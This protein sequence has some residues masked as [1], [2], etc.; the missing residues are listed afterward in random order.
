MNEKEKAYFKSV[1]H[2]LSQHAKN[3]KDRIDFDTKVLKSKVD[4][5][6]DDIISKS[7][8]LKY[9]NQ[10]IRFLRKYL[11]ELPP[12]LSTIY[13]EK[14]A[15]KTDY[16]YSIREDV[17][18][19]ETN[20]KKIEVNKELSKAQ[21]GRKLRPLVK[22]D[23]E[24]VQDLIKDGLI[25]SVSFDDQFG[26]EIIYPPRLFYGKYFT[27][28]TKVTVH[29]ADHCSN[30]KTGC[31]TFS[32]RNMSYSLGYNPHFHYKDA[33][34]TTCGSY[35]LGGF[36]DALYGAIKSKML[37]NLIVYLDMYLSSANDNSK[38]TTPHPECTLER[39]KDYIK[40]DSLEKFK[41]TEAY[42]EYVDSIKK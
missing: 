2:V 21:D 28:R 31:K 15:A 42:K 26:I 23:I 37:S 24:R 14:L 35:C 19:I 38:F 12:S 3:Y 18:Q 5:I 16:C 40:D 4:Q 30:G 13:Q 41:T 36:D 8:S 6:K 20:K 9:A 1:I 27:G 29:N 17:L 11:H 32:F 7:R 39:C 22:T 25:E 33:K 10:E 34:E